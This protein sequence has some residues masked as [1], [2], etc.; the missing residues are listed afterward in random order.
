[1]QHITFSDI[2]H[3]STFQIFK[4]SFQRGKSAYLSLVFYLVLFLPLLF[5]LENIIV[6]S[7]NTFRGE[8]AFLFF[9]D[10][11]FLSLYYA[12]TVLIFSKNSDSFFKV[13]ISSFSVLLKTLPA[14]LLASIVYYLSI[15][16]GSLLLLIPGVLFLIWFY[17]YPIVITSEKQKSL[18][19]FNRS[20]YLLKGH[21]F[22]LLILLLV[23]T[24][25]RYVLEMIFQKLQLLNGMAN[26]LVAYTLSGV[27][28]LP[29]EAT[30]LFLFYLSVRA[31]KEAFNFSEFN[32][33]FYKTKIS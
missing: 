8:Q 30:A 26:D 33:T 17:L 27:L 9:F 5:F 16:F 21:F 32:K 13:Q 29:F 25:T 22:Q 12:F 11:L 20:R 14:I 18:A 4:L 31:E 1:M 2:E 15:L 19:S 3:K 6:S 10:N 24:A 23:Y 28:T 7:L